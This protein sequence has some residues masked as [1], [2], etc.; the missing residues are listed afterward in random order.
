MTDIEWSA[1]RG[2]VIAA[3]DAMA[4]LE[5]GDVRPPPDLTGAIHWLVDDTW[6]DRRS[7]GDDIGRLLRTDREV[8]AIQITLEALLPV[9]EELGPDKPDDFY[10]RH[11]RWGH[12]RAAARLARDILTDPR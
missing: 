8:A 10:F 12:V 5:Y 2:D 11:P 7:P 1:R 3:L 4:A 9:L 6:W